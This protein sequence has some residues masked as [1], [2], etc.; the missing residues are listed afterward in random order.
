MTDSGHQTRSPSVPEGLRDAQRGIH[1]SAEPRRRFDEASIYSESELGENSS[2]GLRILIVYDCLFPWSIGGAERWYRA[3]AER[4]AANGH[5]VTYLT[6]RQWPPG[7]EPA[8][9]GVRVIAVGPSLELYAG[10]RRRLWP[11]LRFGLGVLWHLIRRRRAY[12]VVHTAAFPYWPLLAAAAVRPR[13][14]YRLLVDWWEVWTAAYWRHYAGRVTGTIGWLVQRA[15]VR[16]TPHAFCFSQLHARRLMAEGLRQPPTLLH[17]VY[18]GPTAPAA[19][20]AHRHWVSAER[21]QA[22]GR[23]TPE[24]MVRYAGRLIPEKR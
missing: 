24:M 2:A 15:C 16:L 12:D 20:G 3:L 14:R 10:A 22:P 17:G 23:S 9:P 8:I 13:G 19:P 11:P 4:L 6:L 5:L 1:S 7:N 21:M 18:P